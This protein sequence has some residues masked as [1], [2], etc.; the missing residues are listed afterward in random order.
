MNLGY[1]LLVKQFTN[2]KYD[3]QYGTFAGQDGEWSILI[4]VEEAEVQLYIFHKGKEASLWVLSG[5]VL[6]LIP[7]VRWLHDQVK[8]VK[9]HGQ[10]SFEFNQ[11]MNNKAMENSGR[12]YGGSYLS[13]FTDMNN[14]EEA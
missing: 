7:L 11:D 8:P 2:W 14:E 5:E 13:Q 4:A 9:T 3:E 1:M 12:G 6:N 10:D